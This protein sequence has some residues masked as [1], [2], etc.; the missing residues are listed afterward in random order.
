MHND[1]KWIRQSNLIEEVDDYMEDAISLGCWLY[2]TCLGRVIPIEE[3][4]IRRIHRMIMC[5]QRP[6]IAGK[7]RDCNVTVGGRLCPDYFKVPDLVANWLENYRHPTTS[8]K[9]KLAHVKFEMIH[10]FEDG[11]GRTGRMLLNIQRYNAGLKTL[12]IKA[13]ERHEYYEWFRQR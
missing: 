4:T 3:K 2:H 1:L 6:D 7:Y 5:K 8:Q 13:N 12:L 9:I 10:P 11:N